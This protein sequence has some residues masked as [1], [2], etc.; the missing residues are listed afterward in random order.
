MDFLTYMMWGA[1]GLFLLL[2]MEKLLRGILVV[3]VTLTS[4]VVCSFEGMMTRT[5]VC[6]R[7]GRRNP[8]GTFC[9]RCGDRTVPYA[10]AIF[11]IL[12]LLLG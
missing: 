7:C 10:I 11:V 6:S 12:W 1:V 9:S 4:V 5:K 3:I 8:G 2:N